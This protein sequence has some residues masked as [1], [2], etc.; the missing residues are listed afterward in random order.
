MARDTQLNT[1]C[2]CAQMMGW[3]ERTACR[4]YTPGSGD[5][6]TAYLAPSI[7]LGDADGR[8]RLVS[9][10][11]KALKLAAQFTSHGSPS[12]VRCLLWWCIDLFKQP[13]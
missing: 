7:P 3:A 11:Y 4:L 10:A 5:A 2:L 6:A 12:T 8:A 9:T 13:Y 1:P